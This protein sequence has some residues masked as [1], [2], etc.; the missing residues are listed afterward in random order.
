MSKSKPFEYSLS[1]DGSV[2]IKNYSESP[3]FASFLPGIAGVYGIPMWVFYVNRGQGISCFGTDTKDNPIVE[4][5]SANRAYQLTPTVGFRTFYR[6]DGKDFHEAFAKDRGASAD[7]PVQEMDITSYGLKIRETSPASGLKTE[8]SYFSVP[9]ESLAAFARKVKITN[10]TGKAM[11]LEILDGLPQMVTSGLN[12]WLL[13]NLTYLTEAWAVVDGLQDRAPY[14]KIK[15]AVNDSPE[16]EFVESGNFFISKS[17]KDKEFSKVVIDPKLIFGGDESYQVPEVFVNGEFNVD[18]DQN[19]L[20]FIPCGFAHYEI[21]LKPAEEFS[22]V[23]FIGSARKQEDVKK[24]MASC[25]DVESYTSKKEEENRVIIEKIQDDVFT[26]T[27]NKKFDFYTRQNYLDNVLRGGLPVQL[28]NE[29]NKALFYL[30]SRKHGDME[31]DYNFFKIA[32]TYFSQG[33]GNY[34]DVNQNRRNDVMIHPFVGDSGIKTFMNLVQLDG[35]NPLVVFGARFFI[36][37]ENKLK[38]FL[39]KTVKGQQPE[40]HQMLNSGYTPG[41]LLMFVEKKGIELKVHREEFVT[42]A[43]GI[44]ERYEHADHSE[45]FWSDHWTYNLDL[46]ESYLAVYPEKKKDLFFGDRSFTYYESFCHV[47]PRR[48]KYFLTQ[49]GVRQY[50]AVGEDKTKHKNLQK[51]K[52]NPF[53]VRTQYGAGEIYKTDLFSKLVVLMLNKVA[54]LDPNGIGIEFEANKPNWYD[55]LNGI[56][57]L[58]GSSLCETYEVKRLI[59]ELSKVISDLKLNASDTFSL[60]RE[61]ARYFNELAVILE[62]GKIDDFNFWDRTHTAKENYR[63]TILNGIEGPE[64]KITFQALSQFLDQAL[65]RVEYGLKKS[66]DKKS[67]LPFSYFINEVT[68]YEKTG[69]TREGMPLVRAKSFKQTPLPLF[70]EG[71]VHAAR[72][73]TSADTVKSIHQNVQKSDLFDKKLKMYKVNASLN[74]ESYEIGRNKVFPSGWLENESVWLHMEYKYILELAKHGLYEDFYQTV[75]DVLVFNLDP[76]VYGRSILE[77]SSFVVSSAYYDPK[78]HGR[79]FYAR[80]TGSTAEFIH[81]WM[82]MMTGGNPF[83]MTEDGT[84]A[85]SLKPAIPG[86]YFTLKAETVPYYDGEGKLQKLEVPANSVAFKFLGEIPVIIHNPSRVDTW[87]SKARIQGITLSNSEGKV[88]HEVDGGVITGEWAEKVRNHEVGKIDIRFL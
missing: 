62:D 5:S 85:L 39:A 17:T 50:H 71:V 60:P 73:E 41:D 75:N 24:F 65:S 34:R 74:S 32:P 26:V 54:T 11:K 38:D 64:D 4:F 27:N 25:R 56:P 19:Y 86:D 66:I 40:L 76:K 83:T 13:K 53:A 45:G 87:T 6:I 30:Y 2:V 44:S 42:E 80:L 47:L 49:H 63:S 82:I 14:Y 16:V 77:N 22:F 57:G 3:A 1:N 68:D 70:L 37:D 51:R 72:S 8:V 31:R 61:S 35:Y 12:H 20:N 55:A 9:N 67:G 46:I 58:L 28:G 52:R 48:E 15:I 79:G 43:I 33:N 23:S 18:A 59:L 88:L 78:R 84:L 21:E 29:K 10:N 36:E 81:M 69:E 7:A